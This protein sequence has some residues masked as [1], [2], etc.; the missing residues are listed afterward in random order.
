[1]APSNENWANKS[2]SSIDR[3]MMNATYP[4]KKQLAGLGERTTQRMTS[5]AVMATVRIANQVL[6]NRGRP[7]IGTKDYESDTQLVPVGIASTNPQ[8]TDSRA[9][10]TLEIQRP[11]WDVLASSF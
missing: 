9:A 4:R 1:M 5:M 2:T 7:P 6:Y 8:R 3:G 10:R 11:R